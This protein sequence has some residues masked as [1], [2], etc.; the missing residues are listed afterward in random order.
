MGDVAGRHGEDG[1]TVTDSWQAAHPRS[2]RT[3][4]EAAVEASVGTPS[5]IRRGRRRPTQGSPAGSC[6][7]SPRGRRPRT[8]ARC[9]ATVSMREEDPLD[10]GSSA[11]LTRRTAPARAF[12]QPV[13]D[14]SRA[15]MGQAHCREHDA[16]R[17]LPTL[18]W[19]R[20]VASSKAG[21]PPQR[22][23]VASGPARAC[24]SVDRRDT[25]DDRVRGWLPHA[26]SAVPLS[27]RRR[28]P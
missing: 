25:C 4:G 8:A 1:S 21:G 13:A 19:R 24:H 9:S 22:R 5:G 11:V 12:L 17:S 7:P 3:G 2:A 27:W 15:G 14:F 20:S 23:W 10:H 16:E 26:G 6:R 28:R 18:A